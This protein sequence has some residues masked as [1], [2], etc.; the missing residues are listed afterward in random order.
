[1][2]KPAIAKPQAKEGNSNIFDMAL[3][4]AK[5][6][7]AAPEVKAEAPTK[8]KAK[9][10]ITEEKPNALKKKKDAPTTRE[11]FDLEDELGNQMRHFLTDSRRFRSKREFLTQ[12][13]IDGLKKYEGQ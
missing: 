7:E 11:N 5:E 2:K 13:V 10:A 9:A 6:G 1:M 3:N 12:C 8:V 4:K